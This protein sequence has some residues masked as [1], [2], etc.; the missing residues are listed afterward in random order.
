MFQHLTCLMAYSILEPE[1]WRRKSS[2]LQRTH[3]FDSS[4]PVL[5]S[6]SHSFW[7]FRE[8]DTPNYSIR[9]TEKTKNGSL[10]YNIFLAQPNSWCRTYYIISRIISKH[11]STR[12]FTT[13]IVW[14][15]KIR[16]AHK[17]H[18]TL[19]FTRHNNLC[20]LTRFMLI[21]ERAKRNLF[22]QRAVYIWPTAVRSSRHNPPKKSAETEIAITTEKKIH[23]LFK[24]SFRTER[25][26]RSRSWATSRETAPNHKT[27]KIRI[28]FNLKHRL[29]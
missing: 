11:T 16:H 24:R 1:I 10:F 18:D 28:R 15:S 8:T 13:I 26:K 9:I 20:L 25:G 23:R 4:K 19:L 29:I 21:Y 17:T 3:C 2:L 12:I 22:I 7:K 27:R 6:N 5:T 14:F